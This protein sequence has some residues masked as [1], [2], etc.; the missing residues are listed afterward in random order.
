MLQK[1]IT[2]TLEI[3]ENRESLNKETEDI[4]KT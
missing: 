3:N 2:N 1:V 4:K